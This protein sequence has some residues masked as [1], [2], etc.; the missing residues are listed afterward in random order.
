VAIDWRFLEERLGAI[1]SDKAGRPPLPTRLMARVSILKHIH[2]LSGEDLSARGIENP[3]Y[4]L[5]CDGM[6]GCAGRP[7]GGMR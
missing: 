2:N 1:Y 6:D 7:A 3:Y 4:R 5:F